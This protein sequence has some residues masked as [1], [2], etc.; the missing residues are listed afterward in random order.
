MD[1]RTVNDIIDKYRGKKTALISILHDIQ[2]R[3]HYLPENALKKVARRLEMD[4][5][6]IYGVA[7]F[8]KAFSLTPRGKHV[9]TVCLGT[10]CHVRQGPKIL[11]EVRRVLGIEPGQT[12]PDRQFSLNAV[13]C[14]G[15]CAI[16]PVM[17]LD[18]K[19]F[20][21]MSP[22]KAR[23]ILGKFQKKGNGGRA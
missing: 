14:L 9:V 17:V 10:A 5:P 2:D 1:V 15:V 13:N 22:M 21:E 20:G 12:T 3:Y 4:L 19:F 18:G 16:G 11:A 7:T 8:Y 23:R 6:E